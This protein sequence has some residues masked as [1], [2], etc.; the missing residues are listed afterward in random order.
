MDRQEARLLDDW[1]TAVARG[2][3][4]AFARLYGR[5][6]TAV[7][8]LAL[9]IVRESGDAEDVMQSTFLRVWDCAGQYRPG[10]DARAWVLKIA[11]NLALMLLRGRKRTVP[12][13]DWTPE[14]DGAAPETDPLDAI[15]LKTLLDSLDEGERQIVMLYAVEGFSHKEI[16]SLLGKPYATVRW[17]YSNA[18]KKLSRRLDEAEAE[19]P[20]PPALDTAADRDKTSPAQSA[21]RPR[22]QRFAGL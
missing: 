6:K 4:D 1:L 3:R 11:R 7:Y 22:A 20:A 17:K 19:E 15:L 13:D 8:G 5:L 14:L 16:A 10:T 21:A 9:S 12:V 18:I 2:D